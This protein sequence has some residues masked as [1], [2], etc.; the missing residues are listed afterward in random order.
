MFFNGISIQK[1]RLLLLISWDSLKLV[2]LV[3]IQKQRL[4]LLISYRML[5][6][7]Q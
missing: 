6:V 7:F 5:Q 4:L 2:A 3:R 1:Q